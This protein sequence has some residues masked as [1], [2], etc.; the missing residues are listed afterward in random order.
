LSDLPS[1]P[2]DRRGWPWTEETAPLPDTISDGQP[3]P[4][5][6][7]VTPSYNQARFVEETIRSVLLQGYPNLEYMVIDGGST[8]GSVEIIKKYEKWLAYWVSEPDRGQSH[9]INKGFEKVTGVICG[10]LNSDDYL[11]KDALKSVARAYMASPETGAWCG[12]SLY[13]DVNGKKTGVREPPPQLD[14]ETIAAWNENSFAQPATFFSRRAWQQCAP[15]DENLHYGMD[16]DLW[17]RI[18]QKFAFERLGEVLATERLHK[19][20]KTEKD[21]GMMYAVQCQIQI[22]HGYERLAMEDIR[23]W[24]NEY[25]AI[26]GRLDRISRLPVV[27]LFRPIALIVWRKLQA[28]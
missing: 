15:L 1:P 23:Q 21:M 16:L 27:R 3:W 19:D 25:M 18:A 20:C 17:I 8:D 5:V 10:W 11:L 26:R 22:R 12:S 7:I 24:M 13:V 4:R 6:S 28:N 9:A 14:A 2:R